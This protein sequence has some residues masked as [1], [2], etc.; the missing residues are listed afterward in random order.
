LAAVRRARGGRRTR[1]GRRGR[2]CAGA[3]GKAAPRV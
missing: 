2:H 3:A 1:G